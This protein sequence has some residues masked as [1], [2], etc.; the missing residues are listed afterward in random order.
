MLKK[1][2]KI[3]KPVP[4]T[5]INQPDPAIIY[6]SRPGAYGLIMNEAGSIAIIKTSKG[7]FLPGGGIE[8]NESEEDCIIRECLEEMGMKIKVLKKISENTY[9]FS[10]TNSNRHLKIIGH[11]YECQMQNMLD[12]PSEADH[13]LIWLKTNEAV[14]S[15]YLDN[16]R[17]AVK[18]FLEIKNL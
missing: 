15:L 14:T 17:Q 3:K 4:K 11:F 12:I 10:S 6:T 13:Q 5:Q 18:Y 7:Y 9:F 2:F 1:L 16:Q 8:A